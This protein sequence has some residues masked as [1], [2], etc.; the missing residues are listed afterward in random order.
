[1]PEVKDVP[2]RSRFEIY[3]DGDRVGVLDYYVSG[4]T[5]TMPHT[6]ID[7]AY[8]GQGLGGALVQGALD[9]ARSRGLSVRPACSFVRHYV[10]QHPEYQDLVEAR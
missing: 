8:G 2:D 9:E 4:D 5:I 1:M 3:V 7:P 10:E 6:E